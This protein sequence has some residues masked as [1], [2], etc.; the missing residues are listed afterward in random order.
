MSCVVGM[1]VDTELVCD[2]ICGY[3]DDVQS[4]DVISMNV[5]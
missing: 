3:E 1:D 4:V 2:G 5:L